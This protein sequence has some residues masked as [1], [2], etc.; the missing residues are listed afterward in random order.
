MHPMVKSL[1]YMQCTRICNAT[2]AEM[3]RM[4]VHASFYASAEAVMNAISAFVIQRGT[5]ATS[6]AAGRP[7]YPY[8]PRAQKEV[9]FS[10]CVC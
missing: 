4:Y 5:K 1:L 6:K 9:S 10:I 2:I 3:I 7:I 8:I